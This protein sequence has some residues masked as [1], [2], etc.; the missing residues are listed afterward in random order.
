VTP[1]EHPPLA[2][3][4]D[5]AIVLGGG[6][7][8]DGQPTPSTLARAEAA[9][10]LARTRDLAVIVSGSH[11]N[12]PAPDRTEAEFMAERIAAGGIDR[13][14]I[15]LEDESRDTLSN[16][17]FVAERYLM[18]L[19]PRR[20]VIV[21]SP[22][23]MAR[24]LATFALVLGE[25]WP[26]EAHP[27]ARGTHEDAHAATEALY[28]DRTHARLEGT[29]PGDIPGIAARVRATLRESVSDAS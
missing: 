20:L 19:E 23:H 2:R 8:S 4:R 11:G 13:L 1:Q 25:R 7:R 15:F 28:L 18:D 22:F 5:I 27:A 21:T 14:R 17:A 24:A 29:S 3:Y 16:A 10:A 12:G 6:L 9:A 26:L